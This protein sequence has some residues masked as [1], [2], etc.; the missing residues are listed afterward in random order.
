LALLRAAAE[1]GES[2]GAP[3]PDVVGVVEE[4]GVGEAEADVV[5]GVVT[6]SEEVAD[7]TVR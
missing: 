1:S 5:A 6:G 3:M 4:A 7:A 2:G